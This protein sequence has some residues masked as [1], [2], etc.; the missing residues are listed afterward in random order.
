MGIFLLEM[1]GKP[2]ML[3]L[4]WGD[5]EFYPHILRKN[6]YI[7]HSP[8]SNFV[9]LPLPPP[10]FS[11]TS[12]PY[13]HCSLHPLFFPLPCFFGWMGDHATFDVLFYL[14][15]IVDLHM[16]SIVTLVPEGPSFVFYAT[17]RQVYWGLAHNKVFHWYSHLISHTDKHTN[18]YSTLRGQ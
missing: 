18:T 9:C 8:F 3:V 11:V 15:I 5:G 1:G 13:T 17:R 10:H 6:P 2:G 14:V 16:L 7:A 4:K 12:N